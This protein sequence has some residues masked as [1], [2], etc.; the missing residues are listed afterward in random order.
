M[1]YYATICAIA[2]DENDYLVEWVDYHL[3]LGFDHIYLYENNCRHSAVQMLV[4]FIEGNKL[5]V[6]ECRI[7]QIPQ[8]K[9]YNHCL[10]EHH[11]DSRWIAFIDIDEFISLSSCKNIGDFLSA[12]ESFPGVCLNWMVYNANG[13]LSK[14]EGYVRECFRNP[15]VREADINRHVKTILQPK[16]TRTISHSHFGTYLDGLF[17]VNEMFEP[18]LSAFS[19][20]SNQKAHI[21]HYYTKSYQE[22]ANKLGRGRP[23]LVDQSTMEELF[24][25]Y[26]PDMLHLV[27]EARTQYLPSPIRI[28][29]QLVPSYMLKQSWSSFASPDI[30]DILNLIWASESKYLLPNNGVVYGMFGTIL[31]KFEYSRISGDLSVFDQGQKQLLE[32]VKALLLEIRKSATT[33]FSYKSGLAGILS[34]LLFFDLSGMFEGSFEAVNA[35]LRA[36][37]RNLEFDTMIEFGFD[38]GLIGYANYFLNQVVRT[39]PGEQ[40]TCFEYKALDTICE[41]IHAYLL[42][43]GIDEEGEVGT[44]LAME[45]VGILCCLRKMLVYKLTLINRQVMYDCIAIIV[46]KMTWYMEDVNFHKTSKI[47]FAVSLLHISDYF[48]S[49]SWKQFAQKILVTEI[50]TECLTQICIEEVPVVLLLIRRV[51]ISFP[52]L[53]LGKSSDFGHELIALGLRLLKDQLTGQNCVPRFSSEAQLSLLG[54]I[55]KDEPRWDT[56]ITLTY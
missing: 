33:D 10:Y 11:D 12:Y 18:V 36:E 24:W 9:V 47:R 32:L 54:L 46:D 39:M 6:R 29:Q 52:N 49:V 17:A 4:Q 21:D 5:T 26:N 8:L 30:L 28:S 35:K 51:C 56:Y 37:F 45:G 22:W 34:A 27:D 7:D 14:P 19:D 53:N 40:E 15:I 44:R 25:R 41:Y 50:T 31:V 55:A 42:G 38:Y 20:F 13:H 3:N 48:D 43:I 23:D 16:M 1:K 2:K